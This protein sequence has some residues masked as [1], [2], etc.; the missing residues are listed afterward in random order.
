MDLHSSTSA[1]T[2]D[3]PYLSIISKCE[4]YLRQ[5]GDN[6]RGV[7]W[8]NAQDA[9]TRYRVMLD[10][11]RPTGPKPATLLDFGCGASHLF[12]FL[13]REGYNHIVYSGLD[14]SRD[15]LALSRSKYPENTYHEVDVLD[16]NDQLPQFDYVIMNGIFTQKLDI[17]YESMFRYTSSVLKAVYNKARVGV[18]FNLHTKLVDWERDDLFHVPFD[19]I[20]SFLWSTLSRHFVIRHDYNLYEYTIYLYRQPMP[21]LDESAKPA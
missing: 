7:G 8:P 11:L 3:K 9:E 15:F 5:H 17:D 20:T 4:C 16:N 10:V 18:A 14:L 1:T 21:K 6:H 13:R 19:R 12:E 2:A